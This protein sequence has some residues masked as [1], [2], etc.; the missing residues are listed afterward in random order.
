M[1]LFKYRDHQYTTPSTN[2]TRS[3]STN[4]YRLTDDNNNNDENNNDQQVSNLE[5]NGIV[6]LKNIGNTVILSILL[7]TTS[8]KQFYFQC[9]M[10]SILQC[11]NNSKLLIQYCI[12]KKYTDDLNTTL[13]RMKGS[14][15]K[16]YAQLVISMWSKSD[17]A[18]APQ[19]FKSKIAF[20][21]PRFVGYSQQ[22]A[23]GEFFVEIFCF[24]IIIIFFFFCRI[25]TLSLIGI[26]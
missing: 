6:G 20:F 10:N 2:T 22:D 21:A 15:F 24:I 7:T 1:F 26:T 19:E 5:R 8:Y 12:R 9:F 16:T 13:S 25:F 14:L 3:S 4:G 18:V 17:G 11:L 23:Q